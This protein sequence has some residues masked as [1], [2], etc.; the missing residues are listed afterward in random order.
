MVPA[1][2]NPFGDNVFAYQVIFRQVDASSKSAS[3]LAAMES[4]RAAAASGKLD[5][6]T[7]AV[8]IGGEI[9]FDRSRSTRVPEADPPQS[10]AFP[11]WGIA[12]VAV[13]ALTAFVTYALCRKDRSKASQNAVQSVSRTRSGDSAIDFAP[14]AAHDSHLSK[15]PGQAAVEV[16]FMFT[17]DKDWPALLQPTTVLTEQSLCRRSHGRRRALLINNSGT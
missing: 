14:T 10:P 16:R 17:L 6:F 8:K 9:I 15:D 5:N 2:S 12:L 13:A 3:P 11:S 4:F 7:V 1:R